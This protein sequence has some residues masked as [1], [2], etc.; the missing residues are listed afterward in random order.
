MNKG[1]KKLNNKHTV[2]GEHTLSRTSRERKRD[3]KQLNRAH[4]CKHFL[5]ELVYT[6][7]CFYVNAASH[8]HWI[9]IARISCCIRRT[10]F[11]WQLCSFFTTNQGFLMLFA[12][13][14]SYIFFF[15]LTIT[16]KKYIDKWTKNKNAIVKN[17]IC[18]YHNL[19]LS[20]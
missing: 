15:L 9:A 8:K 20:L 3:K 2:L 17:S 11:E 13:F 5:S 10:A 12:H 1:T 18:C 6:L 16:G 7:H 14:F 19:Q 4:N